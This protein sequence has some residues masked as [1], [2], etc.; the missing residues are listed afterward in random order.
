MGLRLG[1][2]DGTHLP[3][4]PGVNRFIRRDD[5][6]RIHGPVQRLS[7]PPVGENHQ[8]FLKL[9]IE[10]RQ[11]EKHLVPVGHVD[12]HARR[13]VRSSGGHLAKLKA[14]RF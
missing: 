9:R 3:N 7:I 6:Q 11:R 1:N 14:G 13:T 8:M 2:R 5:A 12:D 10:F 4:P